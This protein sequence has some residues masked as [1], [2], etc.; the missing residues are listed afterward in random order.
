MAEPTPYDTGKRLEPHVWVRNGRSGSKGHTRPAKEEEYGR[1]DFDLDDGTTF[2]T[3]FI[4]PDQNAY[5]DRLGYELRID[6]YVDSLYLHVTGAYEAP[7]LFGPAAQLGR[8]YRARQM[9]LLDAGLEKIATTFADHVFYVGDGDPSA[10]SPGHFVFYAAD[11]DDGSWFAIEE[12]YDRPDGWS[13]PEPVPIGWG[14][15]EY[16]MV[17]QPDG[18][19]RAERVA[20]GTTIPSDIDNLLALSLI[21]I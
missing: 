4:Q 18:T 11:A 10:F 19:T 17:R 9:M 1:V 15:N 14:W 6:Q 21:H 13:D 16:G 7:R 3:L 5:E 12:L 20:E 2:L 8:E